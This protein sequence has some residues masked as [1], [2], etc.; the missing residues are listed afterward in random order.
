MKKF[1]ITTFTVFSLL[2]GCGTGV[3]PA[4]QSHV[5]N[6]DAKNREIYAATPTLDADYGIAPVDAETQIKEYLSLLLKDPYSAKWS[7][8]TTPKKEYIFKESNSGYTFYPNIT[9]EYGYSSCIAVNAKNS[10]GAYGG[11][12][13]YWAF[14]KNGVITIVNEAYSGKAGLPS[15]AEIAANRGRN[16]SNPNPK[17]FNPCS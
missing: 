8:A 4:I 14:F 10:Y 6:L 5:N 12:K 9:P 7:K 16:L 13:M 3:D 2:Q 11:Q 15:E 1:C 17:P